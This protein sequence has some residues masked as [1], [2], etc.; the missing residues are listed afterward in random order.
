MALLAGC[1]LAVPALAQTKPLYENNFEQTELGKVPEDM[2]VLN[3]AF[4][5]RAEG[6]NKF[7]EL[8]GAPLDDFGVM[9][10]PTETAGVAVSARCYGTGRARRGPAFAVGLNGVGGYKLQVS[11]AKKA[12]ELF[13]GE[14]L[15]ASVP[16]TWES[17][18]WTALRLQ[19]RKVK[20][21]AW[22][23][24]GR[25]WKHGT[26]EPAV[27]LVSFDEKTEPVA[28]RASVS[29]YPFSGT[30]IGFDDLVVSAV[31]AEAVK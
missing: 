4:A 14:E 22:K 13:K 2:L 26:P 5:V 25:A 21:G 23:V 31:G 12:L 19:V 11:P 24:E 29:G 18:T 9:F 16:H 28:G 10:G 17:G 27:W 15:L 20:D 30:P 7:L 6:G 1:A 8:P 3:G